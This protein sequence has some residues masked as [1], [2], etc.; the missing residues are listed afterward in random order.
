MTRGDYQKA[1]DKPCNEVMPAIFFGS[2]FDRFDI[3]IRWWALNQQRKL[4]TI[5]LFR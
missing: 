4:S 2:I 1:F 3:W 5:S